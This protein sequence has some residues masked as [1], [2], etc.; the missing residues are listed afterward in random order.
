M[1]LNKEKSCLSKMEQG[2]W[3]Y[4][5]MPLLG[6]SGRNVNSRSESQRGPKIL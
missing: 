4:A 6:P 5:F 1:I 3:T 2:F